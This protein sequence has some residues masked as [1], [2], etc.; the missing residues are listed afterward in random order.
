M[1]NLLIVADQP[2]M[3]KGLH[4]RL[5][6]EP[7]L[8]VVGEA[9]D[10]ETALSLAIALCPDIVLID[11]DM[12]HSQGIATA[13]ALHQ[14]CPNTRVIILSIHDDAQLYKRAH[15]AYAAAF[16]TK[17]LPADTLINAIRQVAQP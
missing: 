16:I 14:A 5:A 10:C 9:L 17:S 2:A 7:D 6:A 13:E 15:D 1:I 12:P 8:C 11:A 3:R 4:M